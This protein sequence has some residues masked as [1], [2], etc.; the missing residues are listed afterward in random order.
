MS[1]ET[2]FGEGAI[3]DQIQEALAQ[4][5]DQGQRSVRIA[6]APSTGAPIRVFEDN[7]YRKVIAGE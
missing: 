4:A 3:A 7:P 6:F 2:V 5:F 1:S